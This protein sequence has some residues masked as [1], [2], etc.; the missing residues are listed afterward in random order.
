MMPHETVL[1]TDK[2]G[3]VVEMVDKVNAGEDVLYFEGILSPGFI[4]CHCHLEL[5]HM[6]GHIP[7][8]T[9]LPDFVLKVIN[10]R[11]Y[12]EEDIVKAIASAEDEMLQDGIAAVGDICNNALTLPQ[13]MTGRMRYHN[14]VEASGF[15]PAKAAER[16]QR[17]E[18]FYKLYKDVM[19]SSI[20]PHAPYSVSPELFSLINEYPDNDLLTIHNQETA[21][22]NI[23]FEKGIGELLKIYENMAIDISFFKPTGKTSLQSWMNYLNKEQTIILVHNVATSALDIEFLQNRKSQI[24][25]RTFMC[26]CPNANLYITNTLPDVNMLIKNECD[27]VLGTDSLA[28]NHQLSIL[29]EM[30]TIMQHFPEV[31]FSTLLKWA[32]SNGSR[33]LRMVEEL[34]SFEKGKKPGIILIDKIAGKKLT[35]ESLARKII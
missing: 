7:V 13:K 21:A 24:A 35:S 29:E 10:E 11:H 31:E 30:K 22:E 32:T 2:E 5:S 23:F 34:G 3:R 6:R 19:P 12:K 25:N 4:N 18:E 9:G 16:F 8:H 33:A 27:I 14:F 28:S 26:L 1:I 17:T 15:I 20:V